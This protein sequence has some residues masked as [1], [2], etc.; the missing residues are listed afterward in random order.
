[1]NKELQIPYNKNGNM[2]SYPNYFDEVKTWKAAE[3]FTTTLKYKQY[4]RG[5]SSVIFIFED[6][7][8]N[9]TYPMFVSSIDNI[10]LNTNIIN[11][12]ITGTFKFVK[13]G[14]NY[15]ITLI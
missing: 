7:H 8:T 5:T 2:M 14:K 9:K 4:L 11:G 6:I 1:M 10:L 15:G 12:E 3:N 13:K